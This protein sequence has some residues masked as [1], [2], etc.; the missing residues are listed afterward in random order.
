MPN[1]EDALKT[2]EAGGENEPDP[3]APT[4]GP[5]VSSTPNGEDF[6][7]V[8]IRGEYGEGMLATVWGCG[9]LPHEANARLMAAAPDLLQALL[10]AQEAL[11]L[12][13]L[14]WMVPQCQTVVAKAEGSER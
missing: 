12:H 6:S 9:V 1:E 8:D 2:L 4:P 11:R 14:L 7:Y 3:V 5:W 10:E 13:G